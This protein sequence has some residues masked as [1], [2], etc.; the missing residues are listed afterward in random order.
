[1]LWYLSCQ[2]IVIEKSN[3][4]TYTYRQIYIYV[5]SSAVLVGKTGAVEVEGS[6]VG[7]VQPE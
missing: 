3:I 5:I 2:Q 1:M 4:Y 7:F 6:G